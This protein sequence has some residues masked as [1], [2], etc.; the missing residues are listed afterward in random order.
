MSAEQVINIANTTLE[1]LEHACK[2]LHT[3]DLS[4]TRKQE[5]LAHCKDVLALWNAVNTDVSLSDNPALIQIVS[6]IA[7]RQAELSKQFGL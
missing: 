6:R 7:G 5:V 2:E 1:Q 4:D 3:P